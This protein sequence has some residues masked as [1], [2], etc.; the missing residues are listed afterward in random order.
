MDRA[1]NRGSSR[2]RLCLGSAIFL[3]LDIF[4]GSYVEKIFAHFYMT[5]KFFLDTIIVDLDIR[6]GD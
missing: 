6:G 4:H 1:G 2:G 3:L 5:A